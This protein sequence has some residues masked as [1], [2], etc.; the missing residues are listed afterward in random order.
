MCKCSHSC[1]NSTFALNCLKIYRA[2]MKA[3]I[4]FRNVE[5]SEE[6][7]SWWVMPVQTRI[8][9]RYTVTHLTENGLSVQRAV[10]RCD[11]QSRTLLFLHS[12]LAIRYGEQG[13]GKLHVFQKEV[14]Q[15]CKG[16]SIRDQVPITISSE[17]RNYFSAKFC[18]NYYRI[19]AWKWYVRK[20]YM[21]VP[22]AGLVSVVCP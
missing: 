15:Y 9:F 16:E 13:Y 1:E 10:R 14:T 8:S 6:N 21:F 17:C 22:T 3:N 7:V 19:L 11:N 20:R 4:S 18:Y 12:I 2:F 5:A